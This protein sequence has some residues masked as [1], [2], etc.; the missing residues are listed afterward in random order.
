MFDLRTIKRS[1]SPYRST[2]FMVENHSEIK[3][4]K[5]RIEGPLPYPV[6]VIASTSI[7]SNT[8]K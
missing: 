4:G 2:T 6:F 1:D 7:L 8:E 5:A 3:K